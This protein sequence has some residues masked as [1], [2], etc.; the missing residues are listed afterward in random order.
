MGQYLADTPMIMH[1]ETIDHDAG[2]IWMYGGMVDGPGPQHQQ[3]LCIPTYSY[4]NGQPGVWNDPVY[5]VGPVDLHHVHEGRPGVTY[6]FVATGTIAPDGSSMSNGTVAG[7]V[8]TRFLDLL[9]D[10]QAEVGAACEL[11]ASLGVNC[12]PCPNGQGPFCIDFEATGVTATEV[13]V[14]GIN[15]ETE[16]ATN[17][18]TEV[19]QAQVQAWHNIG[20]CP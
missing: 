13:S 4:N 9:I 12:L 18:L 7:S 6:D 20:L 16:Q 14:T 11:L 17:T 10:P 2:Q 5:G 3:D 15:P 8:D 19:D 1:V